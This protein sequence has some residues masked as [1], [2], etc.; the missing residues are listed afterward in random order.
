MADTPRYLG[1]AAV[2]AALG[3]SA[4]VMAHWVKR[5][6]DG[7]PEPDA[8]VA[9]TPHRTVPVWRPGRDKEWL[10]WVVPFCG[11]VG[12]PGQRGQRMHLPKLTSPQL[13]R[14]WNALTPEEQDRLDPWPCGPRPR[15]ESPGEPADLGN[16]P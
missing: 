6:A 13:R 7:M 14:M 3:V 10:V 9:I 8:Y 15:S 12:K 4:D 1:Q 5:H 11:Q 2:A 16:W